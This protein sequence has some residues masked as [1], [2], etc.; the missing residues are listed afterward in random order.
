MLQPLN[1]AGKIPFLAAT[2][3]HSH[4]LSTN[5]ITTP[6]LPWQRFSFFLCL[7]PLSNESNQR[8]GDQLL[9]GVQLSNP[10]ILPQDFSLEL[11]SQELGKANLITGRVIP[12]TSFPPF[13]KVSGNNICSDTSIELP[14]VRDRGWDYHRN[15]DCTFALRQKSPNWK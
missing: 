3:V 15:E 13:L 9:K 1:V 8:Q 11:I 5:W 10:I 12:S 4:F 7:I 14:I 6:A 2:H